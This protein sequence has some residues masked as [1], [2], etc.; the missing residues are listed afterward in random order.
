MI[1]DN[2]CEFS[3]PEKLKSHRSLIV[4]SFKVKSRNL[5]MKH[6]LNLGLVTPEF[7]TSIVYAKNVHI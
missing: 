5:Q 2:T 4:H 3:T 1:F 7:N 6:W